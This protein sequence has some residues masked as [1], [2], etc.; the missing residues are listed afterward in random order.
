MLVSRINNASFKG[1]RHVVNSSGEHLYKFN[2][3]HDETS[4]NVKIEFYKPDAKVGDS[5]VK[6]IELKNADSVNFEEIPEFTKSDII[7]YRIFVNGKHVV[8]S[9][10][11]TSDRMSGNGFNLVY[12]NSTCPMVQ[13]QAILTMPDIHRPGAYYS[14]FNSNEPGSVKYDMQ[15]QADSESIIRTFSNN[16][17]GSLAGIEYD[18]EDLGKMGVKKVFMTPIW[19]GDNKSS[20][21]YWNKNDMQISD[22]LGNIENYETMLRKLYK[23]GMQY[24][25]DIAITSEG[26][27][28]I[29]VQYAMRWANQNPQTYYWFRM[30]GLKNDPLTLGVVPK[31]KENLRH[32]IVNPSVVYNPSN[33]KIERNPEYNP[34]KETYFQIYDIS[35]VKYKIG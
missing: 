24:V 25:D 14:D 20:H 12:K 17:G 2:Y 35:Q 33:N 29:H 7:P 11:Y 5:P 16:G 3:P 28:G 30:N 8:D 9:G 23:N 19:G 21:H 34:N 32:R 10:F 6:I 26:L 15:K 31:N 22:S 1:Y 13:G 27:E 4:E 18:I